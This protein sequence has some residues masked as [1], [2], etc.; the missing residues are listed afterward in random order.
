MPTLARTAAA[1][2]RVSLRKF[3]GVWLKALGCYRS[4]IAD[5]HESGAASFCI[6]EEGK[7]VISLMHLNDNHISCNRMTSH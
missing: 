3:K 1:G 4:R 5:V 2:A 7:W 6:G